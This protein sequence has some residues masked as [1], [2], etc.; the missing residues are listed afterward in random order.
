MSLS[1]DIS[2]AL[3]DQFILSE[4]S[5]MLQNIECQ[6]FSLDYG[7]LTWRIDAVA[8]HPEF[9]LSTKITIKEAVWVIS[10]VEWSRWHLNEADCLPL[11]HFYIKIS[12]E[13]STLS[14]VLL[15]LQR[16]SDWRDAGCVLVGGVITNWWMH[17]TLIF[18]KCIKIVIIDSITL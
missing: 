9:F 12:T 1:Q 10:W 13:R 2:E 11:L 8:F 18:A 7:S 5:K 6:L 4:V 17:I 3:P 14:S 16:L 15:I